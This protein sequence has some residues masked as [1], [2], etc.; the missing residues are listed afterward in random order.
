M[1]NPHP[2][3]EIQIPLVRGQAQVSRL[4]AALVASDMQVGDHR[5]LQEASNLVGMRIPWR[6]R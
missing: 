1:P 5:S 6:A 2:T 4:C 3:P